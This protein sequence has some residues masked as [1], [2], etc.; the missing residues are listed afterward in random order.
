MYYQ[1]RKHDMDFQEVLPLVLPLMM[2][3]RHLRENENILLFPPADR[4]PFLRESV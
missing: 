1:I 2:P 4:L 3:S